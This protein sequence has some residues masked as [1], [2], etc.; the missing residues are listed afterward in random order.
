MTRIIG[1]TGGIGSGKSTVASYIASKGIPVYIADEEAKKL[2]DSKQISTKIQAIFS[3][4]VLT[5]E[6]KL[7]R[8]KIAAIVFNSPEKLSKL[9]AIVHPEV[10][11]H[12]A[13]WLKLHKNAPFIIKEVAILFET[14]GNLSC[15]KVILVTAPEEIRIQR[16]MK[17]DNVDRDSVLRRIQN[18]LPEEEKISKSD[19]VVHNID[20]Q[21][22]FIEI[23]QILKIL[24][25]P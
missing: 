20:L 7:D 13:N 22:T 2:M 3:E 4:N 19:F 24:A 12:F 17:R 8:K 21:N 15:D 1:L 25:K 14:A 6:G 11:K 5:L 16:A 10:K 9:N 23:D 18:Q